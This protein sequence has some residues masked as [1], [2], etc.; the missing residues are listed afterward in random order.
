[1]KA[2]YGDRAGIFLACVLIFYNFMACVAYLLIMGSQT[3]D[4][5]K[6]VHGIPN[7]IKDQKMLMLFFVVISTPLCFLRSIESLGPVST[8][9][10][11][12]VFF[13]IGVVIYYGATD[14]H[15]KPT[16]SNIHHR[17]PFG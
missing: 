9:G 12:S 6:D 7:L 13:F 1:M 8:L 11:I 16:K 5:I 17:K 4:L 3:H 10:V 15:Y 14:T 2:L